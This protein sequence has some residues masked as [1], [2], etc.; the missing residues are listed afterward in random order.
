[1]T[2]LDRRAPLNVLFLGRTNS[3]RSI[4]A[5]AILN[6]EGMGRFRAFSA[7][8]L[9]SN[10]V[11]P[12]ALDLL[13]KLNFDVAPLRSKSW[14]EFVGPDQIALDFVFSVCDTAA[15]ATRAAWPGTPMTG[16]WGLPDPTIAQ[17]KDPEIH[18]AFADAFRMLNIR[19][20]I[21]ASLPVR[22]LDEMS[23]QRQIDAIARR[24]PA[25]EK[26]AAA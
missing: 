5:E 16:H 10:E 24:E 14:L 21:F 20:G 7:G 3:A 25:I 19:V 13:S 11:H 9:P 4:M 23:L 15:E 18:L 12:C 2:D 6:R 17:G 1:M 22:S 26:S 8:Y